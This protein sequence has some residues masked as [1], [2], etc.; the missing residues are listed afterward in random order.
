MAL[1]TI[2]LV[3][4]L[5]V[6]LIGVDGSSM[7]PTLH[8]H[9]QLLVSRLFYSEPKSGDIVVLTKT[10]FMREPIVKRIIAVE[11]QTIDIDF[12]THEVTVDGNVLYEPYIN[13]E[14]ASPGD[15]DFPQTVPEGCIFVMGDNRNGSTDSRWLRLGMVDK[16]CIL[17]RVLFRVFPFHQIGRVD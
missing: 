2:V 6:R 14:T 4:T 16:R 9:D 8:D 15:M 7:V 1:A 5:A 13:E 3:F 17:G 10:S 11:G 12:I